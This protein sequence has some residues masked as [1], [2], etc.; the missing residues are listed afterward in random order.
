M[1]VH[2]CYSVYST[3]EVDDNIS[4]YKCIYMMMMLQKY[5][6]ELRDYSHILCH[7]ETGISLAKST[8]V[9]IHSSNGQLTTT[10]ACCYFRSL[11]RG[12]SQNSNGRRSHHKDHCY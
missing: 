1:C 4:V 7:K 10:H 6:F 3:N 5:Q 9:Q 8:K 11:T 12:A 2:C